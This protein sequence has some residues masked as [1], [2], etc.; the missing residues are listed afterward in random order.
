M[1]T[2]SKSEGEEQLRNTNM[3]RSNELKNIIINGNL[4]LDEKCHPL[5]FR[6]TIMEV[7]L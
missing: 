6:Q 7:I 2:Q 1:I 4:Q 5:L 3:Q